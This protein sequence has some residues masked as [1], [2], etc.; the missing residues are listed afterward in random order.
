MPMKGFYIYHK[1]DFDR[2]T[3]KQKQKLVE[4]HG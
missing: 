3:D 2:F 1:K 4:R